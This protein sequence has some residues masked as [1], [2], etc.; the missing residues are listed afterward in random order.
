[1]FT[2]FAVPGRLKNVACFKFP[3]DFGG[4]GGGGGY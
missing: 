1:M 3:A 2:P 4:S